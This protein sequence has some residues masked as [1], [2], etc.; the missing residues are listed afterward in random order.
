MWI[1]K[2][3][4]ERSIYFIFEN[5]ATYVEGIFGFFA[6]HLGQ[7][8][9]QICAQTRNTKSLRKLPV[10]IVCWRLIKEILVTKMSLIKCM[11]VLRKYLH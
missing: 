8:S 2:S 7:N 5:E 10:F 4:V 9:N 11:Q 3:G 1:Q 6:F